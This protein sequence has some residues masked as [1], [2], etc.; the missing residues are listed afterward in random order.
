[1]KHNH[2]TRDIKPLGQCPGCDEDVHEP[3]A[4]R[5]A[6]VRH[7]YEI[8]CNGTL[9]DGSKCEEILTVTYD[10]KIAR[11][12]FWAHALKAHQVELQQQMP[13]IPYEM[14]AR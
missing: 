14:K 2:M 7:E 11:R 9:H 13:P 4:R 6:Q 12:V 8:R 3:A 1:M 5:E 10:V